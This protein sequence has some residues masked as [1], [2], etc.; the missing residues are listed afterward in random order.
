MECHCY[1]IS[2]LFHSKNC[3]SKNFGTR[4]LRQANLPHNV[5]DPS[6]SPSRAGDRSPSSPQRRVA[7]PPLLSPQASGRNGPL[8]S[9]TTVG[10]KDTG[11]FGDSTSSPG[12]LLRPTRVLSPTRVA[13]SPD[14]EQTDG[15]DNSTDQG[16]DDLQFTPSHAGRSEGGLPRTVPLTDIPESAASPSKRPEPISSN[17][18]T[19]G[20]TLSLGVNGTTGTPKVASLISSATGTRYGAGLMG[21]LRSTPTG[22]P[23][24]QWGSGTPQCPRCGKSVYFAEQV[25]LTSKGLLL[26]RVQ[27]YDL[28]QN[29][30]KAIGKTWHK[31]CLR[32][33]ECGT[34]LD[35]NRLTEKDGDPLCHRC[36]NKVRFGNYL[37]SLYSVLTWLSA[38]AWSGRQWI[39]PAGKGGWLKCGD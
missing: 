9:P 13:F 34:S 6:L 5:R 3:H 1:N 36:Y 28:N 14:P 15:T 39:R 11:I 7:S 19:L 32:C 18:T 31:G 25:R 27:A 24:R 10:R 16:S 30:V 2:Y 38:V 37:N 23:M 21:D 17:S 12:P 29:Q 22:S 20:R 8:F 33:S 35:S 4:D 26:S